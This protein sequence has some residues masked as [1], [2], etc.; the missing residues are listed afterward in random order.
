MRKKNK[1]LKLLLCVIFRRFTSWNKS[2]INFMGYQICG[3]PT[4][5]DIK[6][7]DHQLHRISN[8]WVTNFIGYQICS[9]YFIGYQICGSSTIQWGWWPLKFDIPWS[10]WPTNLISHEVDDLQIWYLMKL[11]TTNLIY[12]LMFLLSFYW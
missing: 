1:I 4:S 11:I 6:F 3:S 2:V 7:V 10:W 8:L 12:T 9:H 5:W